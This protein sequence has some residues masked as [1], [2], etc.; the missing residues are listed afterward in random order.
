[1]KPHN[2]TIQ[3][4]GKEPYALQLRDEMR[5]AAFVDFLRRTA[6]RHP[7]VWGKIVRGLG[8]SVVGR[9]SFGLARSMIASG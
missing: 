9:W 1:M 6:R 4:N 7:A 3:E 8:L 5:P 2:R